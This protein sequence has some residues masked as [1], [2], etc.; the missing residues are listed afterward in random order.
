VPGTLARAGSI[1][2]LLYN[3]VLTDMPLSSAASLLWTAWQSIRTP[4]TY[5]VDLNYARPATVNGAYVLVPNRP[6]ILGLVARWAGR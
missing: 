3:Y 5:V 1:S 6:A 4:R 2:S